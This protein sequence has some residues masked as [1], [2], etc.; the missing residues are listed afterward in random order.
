MKFNTVTTIL[1][2]DFL[3]AAGVVLVLFLQQ[4][5]DSIFNTLFGVL[6]VGFIP[7]VG[8]LNGLFVSKAWGGMK[9]AVGRALIFLSLGLI[10]WGLG[11]YIFSGI[12]NLLLHIE[13]PYPSFADVGYILALPLWAIGIIELSKATGARFGLRSINGKFIFFLLPLIVIA[14]SYYLLVVVARGGEIPVADSGFLKLFFDFTYPI[15]DVII[16]TLATVVYGL[17]FNYFGG[18]FKKAIFFILASFCLLYV[19][20]FMFSYTTTLETWYPGDWIDLLFAAAMLVMSFGI[21]AF[22]VKNSIQ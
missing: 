19:A 7:L 14:L 1:L 5:S 12:Y 8:G 13:V 6:F 11:T 18:A 15:G 4:T 21:A 2:I 9:S 17:S 22:D 16:L 10:S 20:D 3:L